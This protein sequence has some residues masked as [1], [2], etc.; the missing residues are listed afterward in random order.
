MS[1]DIGIDL[2]T[3]N[4]LINVSGK[5]IVIDEPSVVAVDT[6]TNKVVAVGTEA[7]E[8]VGRTPGNIRVIRPLKDGVIADFDITEAML[9]YF[10]DKLNV[11]GFMSK[12]N[13]L[14]CTPTGVTSI[15]Q[16]AIIQAAEKSGGGKVY[17][18]YEPK[19]A[20]VGA[21]LDIFKPQGNMVIDIGGGTTDIAILSMGEIVTSKSLRYAGDRMNQAIVNYIKANHQL[22]IGMRTAEAIKIE[23][24]AATDPDPD[25]SM[26]VRGR[27][28]IDGLPKQIKVNS[29]EVTEALQEGLQSIIDTTKQVLQETPPELSA[30]IIDRGIMITGGSALLKNIDKLIADSLQVPVLIAESPLESVALGTGILLQHI[31][32]H[33]RH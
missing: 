17:L 23:I 15:E 2:G 6:N 22:L 18:D 7:Y 16:K 29:S 11:K 31:E 19:V 21:G 32:K 24:G 8:M 14:V 27:D 1:K 26:N 4:V 28:T 25:V 30:D 12:P 33:E 13:I 5:G 20:A 9:S 10:I 3:A